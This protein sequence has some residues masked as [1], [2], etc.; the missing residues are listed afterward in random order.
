MGWCTAVYIKR[1]VDILTCMQETSMHCTYKSPVQ[2][3]EINDN[4]PI[5]FG[6]D[7]GNSN[8]TNPYL[9]QLDILQKCNVMQVAILICWGIENI[10]LFHI[11]WSNETI[12]DSLPQPTALQQ[13]KYEDSSM[14]NKL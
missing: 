1:W 4:F 10:T 6:S 9:H 3:A 13:R 12:K 8:L 11:Y 7:N 14:A 2:T 5:I